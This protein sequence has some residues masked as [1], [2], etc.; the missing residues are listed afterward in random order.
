MTC[1]S[2]KYL[3]DKFLSFYEES[4]R[5]IVKLVRKINRKLDIEG[6]NVY[7]KGYFY[8]SMIHLLNKRFET[9]A[10][11]SFNVKLSDVIDDFKLNC[12][13]IFFEFKY[14]DLNNLD[15]LYN[16]HYKKFGKYGYS[17]VILR[18]FMVVSQISILPL[19]RDDFSDDTFLIIV[20]L[21]FYDY[22]EYYVKENKKYKSLNE[23]EVFVLTE[24]GKEFLQDYHSKHF[25]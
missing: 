17:Q 18:L 8:D 6:V 23:S 5:L 11:Y 13:F 4:F 12:P 21:F 14:D 7:N 2:A 9:I 24:K 22:E 16:P 15:L 3:G 10:N 1:F 19:L 20:P 25:I